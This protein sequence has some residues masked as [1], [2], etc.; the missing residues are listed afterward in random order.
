[1]NAAAKAS[2]PRPAAK[3]LFVDKRGRVDQDAMYVG[4]WSTPKQEEEEEEAR[5]RRDSIA[6]AVNVATAPARC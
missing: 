2:R 4:G 5:D 3:P 1:M 6:D